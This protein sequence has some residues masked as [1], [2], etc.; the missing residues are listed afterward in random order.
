MEALYGV[1]VLVWLLGS[2]GGERAEDLHAGRLRMLCEKLVDTP[3]RG[4]VYEGAGT[5]PEDVLAGGAKVVRRAAA[6]WNIPVEVLSTHP[7][8]CEA[9]TAD[10]VAAV[11]RL[12][13]G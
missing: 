8:E 10:A 9:W 3:V 4:L 5:L 2:A 1:T 11:D 6:T 12:L 7:D 13:G